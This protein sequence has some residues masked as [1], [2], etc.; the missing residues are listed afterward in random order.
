MDNKT[1]ANACHRCGATAY[2]PVIARDASG[3]MTP[4]GAYRC[5]QCKLE[6]TSIDQWRHSGP[7]NSASSWTQG[8]SAA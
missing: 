3:A 1:P 2:R 4:S 5:V 6:F 8:R 7:A